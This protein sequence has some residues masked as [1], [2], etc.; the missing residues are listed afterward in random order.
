MTRHR[1]RKLSAGRA[2]GLVLLLLATAARGQIAGQLGSLTVDPVS[3]ALT[4]YTSLGEWNT[5]GNF[6]GWTTVQVSNT[7]ISGGVLTSTASGKEP[8]L[9]LTVS[10]VP[11]DL[12]LA[13]NDY[14]D[15][16]LQV[17]AGF[18]G[19]ISLYYGTTFTPEINT[20]SPRVFTIPNAAIPPDGAFHVYRIFIG[21]QVYWR[22]SL[23]DVQLDP[24]GNSA[25]AG[26][27]FAVDYIRVGDLAG[28]VYYPRYSANCPGPGTNDTANHLPVMDMSSKH[29][30]V[31]WDSAVAASSFWRANMPHG[32][33]RNLE[34]V[35][36]T[37]VW[38]LGYREP[39][40][41]WTPA[42]RDGRK[43]KV[44]LT[45][46]YSGYWSG[47]DVN[48][49]GWIN[50]TPDGLQVDPPTWVPPHEF[51]HVLQMH[52]ED[53]G[54]NMLGDWWESHANY[55]RERWLYYY[56][57]YPNTSG[58]DAYFADTSHFYCSHGRHYYLCWPLY[59]YLDE[60]PDNL[61][62]LGPGFVVKLW[63]NVR[64]GEYIYS[65]IQRFATN[66]P[67]Q[68]LIGYYARRNAVWDYSH[69]AA[70]QAAY[71]A[72]DQDL[73]QRWT[74]AELRQR[75]D[76][77]TWWQVPPEMA[78]MQGAYK[79]H[80]LIPQGSGDG[81]V[82]TV[83]FHGL[84]LAARGADWRVGFVVVSDTGAVRYS[85][86]WNA[87]TNSVT[88]A[89]NEN[90]LYLVVAGTPAPPFLYGS[91]D[92]TVYPYQLSNPAN[93]TQAL[94][95]QRT[96]FPYELQVFGA[97][98]AESNNG[99]TAGLVQVPNGGGWRATTAVVDATAYVGPNARV[100]GTAQVRNNARIEDFAVVKGGAQVLNNAVVSGHALVRNNAIVKD[101]AK[102]RDYAM[103]IDNSVVSGFAR[104][105]QH[106]EV[107]AGSLVRDWATIKGCASTWHDNSVTTNAQAWND[108]VLDGDFSTA[109]SV[110]N[111][112][113]F[114]FLPYNP[115]PLDWITNRPAPRRLYADYEFTAAHDSLAKDFY[116][117]TDGYL[118]GGP[119]WV[120]SD[121]QRSGFLTFDG[122]GQYVILD[123][124]L[125][126]LPEISVTAWIKW[127]GGGADQP[128]WHF[129]SA[130]NHCMFLTPDDGTGHV[131]FVIRDGGPD[132][133]LT[134]SAPLSPGI[135]THVAVTLSNGITGR[136]Y[137]QGVLEDQQ[138]ITLTPDQLNAPDINTVP[139][140]N[141]LG[142][143]A[144]LSQPF[145]NGALD[146]V[147]V[148]TGPLTDAEIGA[149]APNHAPVLAPL[150]NQ[151]VSVGIPLVITNQATDA[152]QPW[153]TLT[154]GLLSAP[155]GST[156]DSATGIYQWRPRVSQAGGVY[157]LA[158][159]V[160]DNG[161]PNLSA[162][163][164]A[165]FTVNPV[166]APTLT[167]SFANGRMTLAVDGD[168]GPDY[169]ILTSTNLVDWSVALST[170]APTLPFTWT[171]EDTNAWPARFYR[172]LLGP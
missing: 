120:S 113:Q 145:F 157:Y 74:Y 89:A 159:R 5:N 15:V 70:L 140:H 17:P 21:P 20:A 103:V 83:N 2:L 110:N 45:T 19:N 54:Q 121:G 34:E 23:T 139:Q 143:G 69:R 66:T 116:G 77:P 97:A 53:G 156:L 115:G 11:P 93:P 38:Y 170:N 58:L 88:L 84:P 118:V 117:V 51:A 14:I 78:P 79:I 136:L 50:I 32:T 98:P 172:V 147:R 9:I 73:A 104:I 86:L 25:A 105:L 57:W 133:T 167:T 13:F 60:N 43:Y 154:F 112:F 134:A 101:N 137:V 151:T 71:N 55:C 30:R 75:P 37:H 62:D 165:F 171:D 106:G 122:A 142:R 128:V 144:D 129:G 1:F 111:G 68:D 52:Q 152:D 123:R 12:D 160:T 24:L 158:V 161:T 107:T 169:S 76:D 56:P 18:T 16:R 87:G 132:Q 94:S 81:R 92:D 131:K 36:K 109:Q 72:G 40:Q 59:L 3:P 162:Y 48:N 149:V 166:N 39:S 28:D 150:L 146:S 119:A 163:Q 80:Q 42:L 168:Y 95:Q 153:Q 61:P 96:R 63:Q 141:Y 90:T 124:S 22:S 100:L 65:A 126:D 127:A 8:Q 164:S 44:N 82:V 49:F 46:F 6:D 31:L 99:G 41:S 33:L 114:G 155:A 64:P 138:A 7:V 35:W 4:N 29:F 47:G 108:A 125:S 135:W 26:Q 85:T 148:Y 67:L 10:G 130:T 102:I 27:T 91:F